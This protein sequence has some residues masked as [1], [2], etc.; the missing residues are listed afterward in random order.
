MLAKEKVTDYVNV[1]TG[2]RMSPK[3]LPARPY[4]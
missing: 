1:K 3:P 2:E 4:F